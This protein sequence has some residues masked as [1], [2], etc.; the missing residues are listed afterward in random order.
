M[1]IKVVL[2]KSFGKALEGQMMHFHFISFS[3]VVLI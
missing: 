3:E 2:E 1:A